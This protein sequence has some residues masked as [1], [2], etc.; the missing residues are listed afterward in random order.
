[1]NGEKKKVRDPEGRE[2]EVVPENW[3]AIVAATA[4]VLYLIAMSLVLFWQLFDIWVGACT[5]FK[6]LIPKTPDGKLP[7]WAVGPLNSATFRLV[8]FTAIGGAM[9]GVVNGFRSFVFWHCEAKGFGPRFFWRYVIFPFLGATL[10]LLVY[11]ILRGGIGALGGDIGSSPSIGRGLVM[12]GI[13]G[14]AGYGSHDV[15]IWLDAQVGRLFAVKLVSVPNLIGKTE[16][17]AQSAVQQ[18]G[19]AWGVVSK[20]TSDQNQVGKVLLQKP[21]AGA[22]VAASTAV[23]VSIG[24]TEVAVPDLIAKTQADAQKALSDAGLTSGKVTQKA[25]GDPTKAGKVIDQS[26]AAKT[27]VARSTPVDLTIGT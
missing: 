23:D 12:F 2:F 1:M 8:A 7:D 27:W 11:A 3:I 26:P 13:G 18:A 19:L 25:A 16:A 17:D 9:G 4:S 5:V 6:W 10:A 14:L 15:F 21:E 22:Q 24:T 20:A